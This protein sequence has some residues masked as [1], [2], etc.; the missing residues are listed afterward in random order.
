MLTLSQASL[1]QQSTAQLTMESTNVALRTQLGAQADE[2]EAKNASIARL[3]SE[4]AQLRLSTSTLEEELRGAETLRRKLHNEVQELR[5]NIRVFARV[6]PALPREASAGL[7]TLRFP[8]PREAAQIELLAAGESATGTATMRNHGF[9]FDRVFRPEATQADVFDEVSHL[10][11]SVLD[12]Y[13]T[14]IFAYGQTGSGKTHSLEGGSNLSL[15]VG[16]DP[17]SDAE[18]GLIPRAVQMLWN[19]AE[20]L[21]DKGWRYDFEGQMLEI[22]SG[23]VWHRPR[24]R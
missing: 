13:N 1:G 7:A 2:L 24:W 19:T 14:C 6:R 17:S 16:A 8:D 4:V 3:E 23:L 5:G 10:T 11:Q 22:V 12:G 18:A 21:Q 9:R 20:S 15:S